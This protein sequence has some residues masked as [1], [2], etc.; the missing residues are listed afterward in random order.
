L[1]DI[2]DHPRIEDFH[3]LDKWEHDNDSVDNVNVVEVLQMLMLMM[4]VV[5]VG[6]GGGGVMMMVLWHHRFEHKSRF[7]PAYRVVDCDYWPQ[8]SHVL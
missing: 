1:V 3:L 2:Y 4:V 6:G 7:S 5:V 8:Q